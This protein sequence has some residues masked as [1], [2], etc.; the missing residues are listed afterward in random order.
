MDKST[1]FGEIVQGIT[2]M[3]GSIAA[4]RANV[5][6][7]SRTRVVADVQV[8]DLEHLYRII[9]RLNTISGIIEII[10]G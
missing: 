3:E 2:A 10:R 8:R 1:L 6:N 9:A 5:V 4:I 7:N